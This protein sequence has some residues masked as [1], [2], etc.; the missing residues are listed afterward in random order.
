MEA[1]SNDGEHIS[2]T[3]GFER[4]DSWTGLCV[5]P[6]PVMHPIWRSKHR[7]AWFSD[8]CLSPKPHPLWTSFLHRID[9]SI[10]SK[11]G[12][13]EDILNEKVGN[14]TALK[15]PCFPLYSILAAMNIKQVDFLNLD[16]EGVEL[17]VLK[18][19]PFDQLIIKV[20]THIGIHF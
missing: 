1:G 6:S 3:L 11:L 20:N 18:T 16:V 13:A 12:K 8:V 15:V 5:E 19:I 9:N 2:S 4:F 10:A 14:W 17:E 7:K